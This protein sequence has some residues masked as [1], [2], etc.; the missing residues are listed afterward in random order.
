MCVKACLMHICNSYAVM[1]LEHFVYTT[2]CMSSTLLAMRIPGMWQCIPT[3]QS[4]ACLLAPSELQGR[5]TLGLRM[6]LGKK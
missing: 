2:G 5:L 6:Y 1:P 3:C 4:L